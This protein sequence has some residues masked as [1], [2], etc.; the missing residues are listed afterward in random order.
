[1]SH[2]ERDVEV[3]TALGLHARPAAAFADTAAGFRAAVTVAK[4]GSEV[5]A[6]SVLLLLTLDVRRGDRL[7]IRGTGDDAVEAVDR[8]AALLEEP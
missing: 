8:L 2:A 5:D 4:N 7:V 1:M 6:T 3:R